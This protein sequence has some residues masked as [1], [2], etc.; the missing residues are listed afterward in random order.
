MKCGYSVI[1]DNMM[2]LE[3]LYWAAKEGNSSRLAQIATTHSDNTIKYHFRPDA[4]SYHVVCYNPDGMVQA[5]KRLR[6]L[7]TSRLG[8]LE[9]IWLHDGV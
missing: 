1:I 4:S 8:R 3:F 6:D 7:P 2:N 5:V 9:T